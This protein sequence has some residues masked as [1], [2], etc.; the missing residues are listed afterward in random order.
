M[1]KLIINTDGA[2]RGNPGP[3]ASSFIVRDSS[4]QIIV[5]E[6]VVLGETTNNVAEYTAVKL[7]FNKIVQEFSGLL[8][9]DVEVLSD[10]KLVV[11]QLSGNFKIKNPNLKIIFDE[12]KLLEEKI[13]DVIY[14]YIPRGENSQADLLANIALD[15]QF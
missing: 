11:E 9:A 5:Q 2:A 10:S 6:G 8:P 13:G 15:E 7:A 1:S 3:A 14:R 12:V 4:G